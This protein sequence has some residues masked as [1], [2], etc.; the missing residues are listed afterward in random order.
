[1]QS[2][3]EATRTVDAPVFWKIKDTTKAMSSF[4]TLSP[5]NVRPA[6]LGKVHEYVQAYQYHNNNIGDAHL[7][8]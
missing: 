2:L 4:A 6:H 7:R 3:T 5:Q 1:M 8:L